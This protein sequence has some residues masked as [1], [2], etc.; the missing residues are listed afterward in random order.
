[1]GTTTLEEKSQSCKWWKRRL[2]KLS[3]VCNKR[4][5]SSPV[6][7]CQRTP[8]GG[9]DFLAVQEFAVMDLGLPLI[10]VNDQV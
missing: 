7:A 6:V 2:A 3:S 4:R 5:N 8:P 9:E 1:M 10:P